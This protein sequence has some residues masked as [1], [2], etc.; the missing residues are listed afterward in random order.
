MQNVEFIMPNDANTRHAGIF[1]ENGSGGFVSDIM[2]IGGRWGWV[3]GSQ[4]YTARNIKFR[5]CK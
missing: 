5:G 1:Q 2:F 3:A 4:Q